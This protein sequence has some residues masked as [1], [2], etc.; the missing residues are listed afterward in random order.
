MFWNVFHTTEEPDSSLFRL[1]CRKSEIAAQI[2]AYS[3]MIQVP[4]H[5]PKSANCKAVCHIRYA[6]QRTRTTLSLR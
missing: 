6:G 3:A 4:S 2:T 1:T 5:A